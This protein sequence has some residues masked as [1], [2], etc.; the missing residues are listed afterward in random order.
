[1]QQAAVAR[2]AAAAAALG[3]KVSP[4]FPSPLKGP[5]GNQEYFLYLTRQD[6]PPAAIDKPRD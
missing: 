1:L 4:A 2:V 5:K 6:E 3:L